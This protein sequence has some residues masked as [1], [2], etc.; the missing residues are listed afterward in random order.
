VGTIGERCT[1]SPLTRLLS[2]VDEIHLREH[3]EWRGLLDPHDRAYVIG[4][5]AGR[6]ALQSLGGDLVRLTVQQ[7][8]GRLALPSGREIT[9]TP[10]VPVGSVFQMLSVAW[11]LP[12][13]LLEALVGCNKFDEALELVAAFFAG[14]VERQIQLGLYRR[15]VEIE[16]NLT[17]VRGR[18]DLAQHLRVNQ[19]LDH[20]MFCRTSDLTWDIP[21]N[22]IVR[23]VVRRLAGWE[24]G[25]PTRHRLE[26][27][28]AA[29]S[30]V[31]PTHYA[32]ERLDTFSH[33]RLNE[34]Y[35]LLH[36]FCRLFLSHESVTDRAG[37]TPFSG[38]LIDMN[39]LFETFVTQTL[40]QR[41]DTLRLLP[42][43][44]LRL[45]SDGSVTGRPD[46]TFISDRTTAIVGDCKYK[47][48]P[49]SD[50][51]HADIYQVVTYCIAAG[52]RHGV[53]VYPRHE[54]SHNRIVE[55]ARSELAL[56]LIAIDLSQQGQALDQACDQ[57]AQ[58]LE[59]IPVWSPASASKN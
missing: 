41:V 26:Q 5:L 31:E 35:A 44:Q 3:G 32:V 57:L 4:G 54:L 25:S 36:R 7:H 51:I 38:F 23:Q 10:K 58:R 29:L 2:P 17:V 59:A 37:P 50:Y 18:I 49:S 11:G 48:L 34:P 53:I 14:L 33:G 43:R 28:Y 45:S 40:I 1:T 30:E 24:F 6:L 55:I 42:Q 39:Q 16:E 8:V 22:Q 20:R 47:I 21:E 46:L 19:G 15:Y 56:H 9:I 13:E 27:L 12:S 52:V